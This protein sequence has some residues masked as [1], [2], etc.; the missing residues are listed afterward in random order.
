M[1]V[2]CH[3]FIDVCLLIALFPCSQMAEELRKESFTSHN[4]DWVE[5]IDYMTRELQKR[6]A[7][8]QLYLTKGK[9]NT[10]PGKTKNPTIVL[11]KEEYQAKEGNERTGTRVLA[12]PHPLTHYWK[13]QSKKYDRWEKLSPSLP[14]S[15]RW[16]VGV[17]SHLCEAPKMQLVTLLC[18]LQ[19]KIKAK[20]CS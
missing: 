7:K 20:R 18:L 15:L 10:S 1:E 14:S 17:G 4:L 19:G 2:T 6:G 5:D 11:P 16:L 13:V 12:V 8:T 3:H 9:E